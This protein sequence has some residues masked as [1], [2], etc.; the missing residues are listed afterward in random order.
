MATYREM[1]AVG[2]DPSRFVLMAKQC[3]LFPLTPWEKKFCESLIA[4]PPAR[5]STRQ[6]E[7]MFEIRDQYEL[8]SKMHGGF[9]VS[10]IVQRVYERRNTLYDDGDEAWISALYDCGAM[11]LRRGDIGRL[12]RCA[13]EVDVMERYMDVA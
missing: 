6:A 11:S 3:F 2:R 13:V 7:T 4:E 8:H 12:R 9:T 1:D 5:L 10:T